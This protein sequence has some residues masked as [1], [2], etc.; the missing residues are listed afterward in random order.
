MRPL[1]EVVPRQRRHPLTHL[2]LHQQHLHSQEKPLQSLQS[3][4]FEANLFFVSLKAI[5]FLTEVNH[6]KKNLKKLYFIC[7]PSCNL[8]L[9]GTQGRR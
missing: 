2:L 7:Q 8:F 5:F 3:L 1:W 6:L 4:I 9:F